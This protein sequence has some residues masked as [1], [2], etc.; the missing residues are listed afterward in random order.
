M[1][2]NMKKKLRTTPNP[3]LFS[4]PL[5]PPVALTFNGF[6]PPSE[7]TLDNEGAHVMKMLFEMIV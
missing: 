3:T 6:G 5:N 2:G 4:Q 1:T 7:R